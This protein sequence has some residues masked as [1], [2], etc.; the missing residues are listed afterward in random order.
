MSLAIYIYIT[1]N[2]SLCCSICPPLVN[3]LE[4]C[5]CIYFSQMAHYV[6]QF[7]HHWTNHRRASIYMLTLISPLG[8]APPDVQ[9]V[10]CWP[11]SSTPQNGAGQKIT[12]ILDVHPRP[13]KM[14]LF[15]I[16]LMMFI[17]S[18]FRLEHLF[19]WYIDVEFIFSHHS[20]LFM[21]FD[22]ILLSQYKYKRYSM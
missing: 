13:K 21:L 8:V 16:Y 1:P 4:F 5:H 20:E 6:A 7:V 9:V 15:V 2:G 12:A 10:A 22:T 17:S 3:N 18:K 19:F 14:T 11:S